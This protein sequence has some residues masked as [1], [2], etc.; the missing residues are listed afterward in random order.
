MFGVRRG[1]YRSNRGTGI[2]ARSRNR[3]DQSCAS[4]C[5]IGIPGPG[6]RPLSRPARRN[7][8]EIEVAYFCRQRPP[9]VAS[10][11]PIALLFAE[12]GFQG[13][14][15]DYY[16]P[17]NSFLNEVLDRKLGIPITLSLVYMHVTRK[18]GLPVYGVGAPGHFLVGFLAEKRRI[19]IDPF[20]N[21]RVLTEKQCRDM[22]LA[23]F[24]DSNPPS[25]FLDPVWPRQVMVRL[26]RNLKAIYSRAGEEVKT[27][28]MIHWIL[29]VDPKS[30]PELRERGLIYEA[31]GDPDRAIRDLQ[32]YVELS[33]E[34]QDR[35]SILLKIEKLEQM[36]T[37]IH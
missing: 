29:I 36:P 37:R 31:M 35:E 33:S 19:F 9:R 27:L 10:T 22:F 25:T 26:M 24:Q 18:A 8:R 32:R 15:R 14:R 13:N 11:R 5:Q 2:P 23:Q 17:R 6:R 3:S 1:S 30:I 34:A 16:D 4:D 20:N 21:G 12:E 28:R 7:G